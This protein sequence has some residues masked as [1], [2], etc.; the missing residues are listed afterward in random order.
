MKRNGTQVPMDTAAFCSSE[1]SATV[2]IGVSHTCLF[3][4]FGLSG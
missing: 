3:G 1:E 4:L 2:V